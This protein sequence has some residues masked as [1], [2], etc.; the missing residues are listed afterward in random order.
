MGAGLQHQQQ[1]E[2]EQE[3]EEGEARPT[4]PAV[5]IDT[6]LTFADFTTPSAANAEPAMAP[7]VPEAPLVSSEVSALTSAG[8]EPAGRESVNAKSMDPVGDGPEDPV[9]KTD[10]WSMIYPLS[11]KPYTRARRS[12]AL[13]SL[14]RSA[15]ALVVLLVVGIIETMKEAVTRLEA[16]ARASGAN[17]AN[18][19]SATPG[20][21]TTV[22]ARGSGA[23]PCTTPGV[24]PRG[25]PSPGEAGRDKHAPPVQPV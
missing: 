19:P 13:M 9:M 18:A 5:R 20:A 3:V 10:A 1:G 11:H 8:D 7:R 24:V 12:F 15:V 6:E 22:A 25:N 21:A 4:D 2:G 17:A 16:G 14:V 23:M